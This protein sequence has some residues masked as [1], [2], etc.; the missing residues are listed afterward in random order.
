MN[1]VQELR[2][3]YSIHLICQNCWFKF[4]TAIPCRTLVSAF[5][6]PCPN[7]ECTLP[8]QMDFAKYQDVTCHPSE[9]IL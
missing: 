6:A 4:S 7:C 1:N 2:K 9:R 5:K 3:T 8:A